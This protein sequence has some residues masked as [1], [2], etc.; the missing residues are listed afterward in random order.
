MNTPLG[1]A[2]ISRIDGVFHLLTPGEKLHYVGRIKADAVKAL[3]PAKARARKAEAGC[4]AGGID[5]L[6][7]GYES[8]TANEKSASHLL[9]YC[10][11]AM[12]RGDVSDYL[13]RRILAAYAGRG[14]RY[15]GHQATIAG[16]PRGKVGGGK[17]GDEDKTNDQIIG[18][19]ALMCEHRNLT[20]KDLWNHYFS[21][22]Y[23]R[24]LDPDETEAADWKKSFIEYDYKDG[25]KQITGGRFANVVSF[26]RNME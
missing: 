26:Y 19:L 6:S 12:S 21:A 5:A 11:Q 4:S 15:G 14:M 22:L 25:R 20:S 1:A 8:L 9:R 3:K 16:K 13:W 2:E 7:A 18:E 17:G 24:G 10:D 23:Q